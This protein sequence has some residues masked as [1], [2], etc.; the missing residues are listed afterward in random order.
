MITK[1]TRLA[2]P[3]KRLHSDKRAVTALEYGL[4]AAVIVT[5]VIAGFTALGTK[6]SDG[7]TKA[8]TCISA[9]NTTGC[10][11]N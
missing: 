1:L 8:G 6:L 9:P 4:V 10:G 11:S 3:I 2:L 7:F 5:T